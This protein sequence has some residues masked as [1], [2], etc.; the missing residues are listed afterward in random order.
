MAVTACAAI[1]ETKSARSVC[2][3]TRPPRSVSTANRCWT[4]MCPDRLCDMET[5][6]SVLQKLY[7]VP[8]AATRNA[9][10]VAAVPARCKALKH[11]IGNTPMLAIRLRYQNRER[12]IYAKAEHLNL[13][14]SIKDRM[15][16]HI[17]KKAYQE[18]RIS[19]SDTIAEATS[20]NTG[21]SF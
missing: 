14:G 15:A 12:V 5:Q 8:N 9:L 18:H 20:G 11:M 21:I 17:L 16:F 13:T 7:D 4:P 3:P 2:W 10:D 19:P 6:S 1:A